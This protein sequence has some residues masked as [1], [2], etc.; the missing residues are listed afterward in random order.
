[1]SEPTRKS[2][3]R[4][5]ALFA[6]IVTACALL[7]MVAYVLIADDLYLY[8]QDPFD[9][10]VLVDTSRPPDFVFPES[11]RTYDLSLN[12]FIDRFCQ[13]CMDARYSDFRLMLSRRIEPVKM[14][15]FESLFAALRQVRIRGVQRLE[16]GLLPAE[17]RAAMPE[18]EDDVYIIQAECELED[19]AVRR[20]SQVKPV[21]LAVGKENGQWRIGPCDAQVQRLRTYLDK[22][23][24]QPVGTLR[25]TP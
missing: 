22:L 18:L 24:A 4:P 7:G 21:E 9:D 10:P 19:F 23:A 14:R 6:L 12:R 1:M 2:G 13:A 5:A 25:R 20:G 15:R 11:L 3:I 16:A 17:A 8:E